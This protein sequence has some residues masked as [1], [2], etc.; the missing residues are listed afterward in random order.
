M[1][2]TDLGLLLGVIG[3]LLALY[4]IYLTSIG[5]EMLREAIKRLR[6]TVDNNR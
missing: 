4:G 3:V 1:T 5:N 2:S 6:K